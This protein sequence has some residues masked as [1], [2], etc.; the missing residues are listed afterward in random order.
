MKKKDILRWLKA[1]DKLLDG[2]NIIGSMMAKEKVERL[3]KRLNK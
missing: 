1:I 3:I 2:Y